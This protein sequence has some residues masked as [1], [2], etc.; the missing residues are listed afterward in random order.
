MSAFG[1]A[2]RQSHQEFRDGIQLALQNDLKEVAGQ[3]GVQDGEM[4]AIV[5]QCATA[6]P[7][8]PSVISSGSVGCTLWARTLRGPSG[9]D[10]L[11]RPMRRLWPAAGIRARII[12][13]RSP[14]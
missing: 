6:A 11:G 1:G 7:Y 3:I 12:R 4:H 14:A 5:G 13:V 2:V 9:S 10:S 8:R